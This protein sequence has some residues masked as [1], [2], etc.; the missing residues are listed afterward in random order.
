[1]E[2]SPKTRRRWGAGGH[3]R[4]TSASRRRA[5]LGRGRVPGAGGAREAGAGEGQQTRGRSAD[6]GSTGRGLICSGKTVLAACFPPTSA[7]RATAIARGVDSLEHTV[8]VESGFQQHRPSFRSKDKMQTFP[9]R[10]HLEGSLPRGFPRR[11]F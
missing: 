6:A 8:N 4:W 10:G 1:M 11:S 2:G 7:A 9:S 3:W 5:G